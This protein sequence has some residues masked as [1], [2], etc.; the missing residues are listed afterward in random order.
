[1]NLIRSCLV[2]VIIPVYNVENYLH[3]CIDSVVN[4]TYKNLEIIL[5]DDS[6]S[7]KSSQICDDYSKNDPRIIVIHKNY[8]SGVSDTRNAG[9]KIAKGEYI[10]FLDSD[11]Y[12]E[13][14]AIESLLFQAQSHSADMV[15][16]D[17]E[18]IGKKNPFYPVKLYTRK[19]LYTNPLKGPLMLEK[20]VENGE[21]RPAIPLI[22]IRKNVL[23]KNKINFYPG[24]LYEDE[25]FT[26]KLFLISGIVV[27]LPKCLYYRRIRDNSIMTSNIGQHH[28][29]SMITIVIEMLAIYRN[30]TT[31]NR[32]KNII[33]NHFNNILLST[34]IKYYQL[35]L[36]DRI[37]LY[38][39]F[40]GLIREIKL[41]H[42]FDNQI[43]RKNCSNIGIFNI[44]KEIRRLLPKNIKKIIKDIYYK[45]IEKE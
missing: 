35:P 10:Y 24:V 15:F 1:M 16:F 12:I 7:D 32:N 11:D 27:H 34:K 42:Y 45:L 43:I 6:S 9:L 4:Q 13:K 39:S 17:A 36:K 14:G 29:K 44:K 23:I 22:F 19:N 3:E 2:S 33:K 30:H 8:N 31:L 28:F 25:L 5:V 38:K 21:Y 37:V 40:K 20:L 41:N 26:L 18:I